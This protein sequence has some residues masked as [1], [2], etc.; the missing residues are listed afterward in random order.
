M[1]LST[2][3]YHQR[4][5]IQTGFLSRSTTVWP[6]D[7][8]YEVGEGLIKEF[9]V[10]HDAAKRGIA[11]VQQLKNSIHEDQ[12]YL[13]QVIKFHLKMHPSSKKASY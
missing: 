8:E 9:E 1:E 11:L 7:E 6:E 2:P 10:V 3:A 13:P 12:K 4:L 5:D